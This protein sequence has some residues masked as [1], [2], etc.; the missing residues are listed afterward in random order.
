MSTFEVWGICY[1]ND[2]KFKTEK[3]AV[4]YAEK[5]GLDCEAVYEITDDGERIQRDDL[6]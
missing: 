1:A 4:R 3:A 2:K 5:L 6:F